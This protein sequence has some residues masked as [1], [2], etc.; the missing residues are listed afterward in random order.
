M[1]FDYNE[2]RENNEDKQLQK[3]LVADHVRDYIKTKNRIPSINDLTNQGLTRAVIRE[4]FQTLHGLISELKKS[5]IEIFAKMF[6]DEDFSE[7][8]WQET[9]A[10]I[11]GEKKVYMVTTVEDNGVVRRDCLKSIETYCKHRN[12]L[13]LYIPSAPGKCKLT[14]MDPILKGK[15]F[16]LNEV[17]LNRHLKICPIQMSQKAIKPTTGLSGIG[18]RSVSVIYP[19]S[20][21]TLDP[22]ATDNDTT[23]HYMITPGAITQPKAWGTLLSTNETVLGPHLMQNIPNKSDYVN[24]TYHEISAMIIEVYDDNYFFM[25][26]AMF[27]IDGSFVDITPEG[28]KRFHP[29][30]KITRVTK[31]DSLTPGDYHCLETSQLVKKTIIYLLHLLGPDK[32]NLHDFYSH[33]AHGHHTFQNPIISALIEEMGL[34]NPIN[35]LKFSADELNELLREAKKKNP[36]AVINLIKSNHDE[37]LEKSTVM[38]ILDRD[39]TRRFHSEA[40]LALMDGHDLIKWGMKKYAGL[41]DTDINFLD[42]ESRLILESFFGNLAQHFHGDKGNRGAKNSTSLTGGLAVSSGCATVG[43]THE[44]RILQGNNHGGFGNGGVWYVGTSQVIKGQYRPEYSKGT[45]G[46][47]MQSMIVTITT[48]TGRILRQHLRLIGGIIGMEFGVPK[49]YEDLSTML[50]VFEKNKKG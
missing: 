26:E 44:D 45:P 33:L 21:L 4:T 14:D 40:V 47:W 13:D 41:D 2:Y 22:I 48:P 23:P 36:K 34:G 31:I 19:S 11:T 24:V 38:K 8:V 37:H 17:F 25:R 32:L 43:H 29:N 18:T 20:R 15:N 1:F 7:K 39:T 27:D 49:E 12:G 3:E 28:Y 16:I 30:G 35:E 10:K 5:D 46:A 50:I 42:R 9:K 6:I